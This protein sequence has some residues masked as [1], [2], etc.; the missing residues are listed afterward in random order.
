MCNYSCSC[1]K[2]HHLEVQYTR[3]RQSDVHFEVMEDTTCG[4]PS[5]PTKTDVDSVDQGNDEL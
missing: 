5:S 1:R 3:L 4:E 2:Y